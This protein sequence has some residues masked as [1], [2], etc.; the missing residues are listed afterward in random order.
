MK[1]KRKKENFKNKAR[2]WLVQQETPQRTDT[3]HHYQ[4]HILL[5]NEHKYSPP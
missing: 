5:D 1:K 3:L 4:S 2:K